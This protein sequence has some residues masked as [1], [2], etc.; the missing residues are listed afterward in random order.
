MRLI[1]LLMAVGAC[2]NDVGRGEP[3]AAG[4]GGPPGSPVVTISTPRMNESFYPSQSVT[5]MWSAVDDDTPTITCDVSAVTGTSSIAI[6]T[7][8][9]ASGT[10]M[11][12]TWS[13][14][15]AAAGAYR[16]RVACT[17]ANNLTGVGLSP[18][19]FVSAPPQNVSFATQI[20]PLLTANCTG[21]ACHDA[22]VPAEGLNLTAAA[23]YG[24][25]VNKPSG[26]CSAYKLVEPTA[27]ERS[28]V[29][30]KLSAG[31][32]CFIGTRM[33]KAAM[34]LSSTQIQLVRDWIYNGAPNN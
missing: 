26:Q 32:P 24:E 12:S 18:Q 1:A 9:A 21:N 34:A 13:I 6:A 10:A 25:L 14:S 23:S 4:V 20:Q 31:G 16:I 3:D 28:Y 7:P 19:F 5:A 8:M 15:G 29:V 2:G 33:P 11:S 17:D 27:P 22:M 30:M